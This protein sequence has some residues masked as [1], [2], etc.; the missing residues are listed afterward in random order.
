MEFIFI[1]IY[2]LLDDAVGNSS[3]IVMNSKVN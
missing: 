1:C 2:G 3:Y